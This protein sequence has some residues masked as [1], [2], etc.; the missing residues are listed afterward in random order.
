[1]L[2]DQKCVP[3]EGG[4][5][6]LKR[7]E[8]EQYLAQVSGWKLTEDRLLQREFIFKNFREAMVFVNRVAELAEAEGHHPD[9]NIHSWNKVEMKLST[10]AIGGLSVNDF[11]MAVKIDALL[12]LS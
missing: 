12:G 5:E 7:S 9:M 1:M 4:V 2:K 8:F 10:H 6:P 11:V 3:C